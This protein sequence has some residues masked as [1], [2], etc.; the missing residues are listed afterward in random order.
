M[1][2]LC[3]GQGHVLGDEAS[4]RMQRGRPRKRQH[5]V[6][7]FKDLTMAQCSCSEGCTEVLHREALSI[8]SEA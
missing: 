1:E 2:A 4:I 8:S 5:V 6:E 7:M 3:T